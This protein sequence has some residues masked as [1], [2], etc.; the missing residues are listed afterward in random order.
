MLLL[1]KVAGVSMA[2]SYCLGDRGPGLVRLNHCDP[3]TSE[4]SKK[5]HPLLFNDIFLFLSSSPSKSC[6]KQLC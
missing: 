6:L 2:M 3:W 5:F 1:E 4:H